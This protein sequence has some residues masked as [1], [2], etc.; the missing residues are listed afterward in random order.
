MG[1]L[2][3]GALIRREFMVRLGKIGAPPCSEMILWRAANSQFS[4]NLLPSIASVVCP[5]CSMQGLKF[6]CNRLRQPPPDRP[7]F[8]K[9]VGVVVVDGVV[10]P[11]F[12][13]WV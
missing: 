1:L 5:V 11:R 13:R 6:P 12:A 9:L 8:D 7:V 10:L 3:S 2:F 4:P